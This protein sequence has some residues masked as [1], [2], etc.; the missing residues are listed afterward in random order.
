MQCVNGGH[1]VRHVIAFGEMAG[2]CFI[3]KPL[4]YWEGLYITSQHV[5][6]VTVLQIGPPLCSHVTALYRIPTLYSTTAT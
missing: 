3:S 1:H 4:S 2:E 5:T 6:V